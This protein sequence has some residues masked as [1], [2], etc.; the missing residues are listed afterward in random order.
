MQKSHTTQSSVHCDE[1]GCGWSRRVRFEAIPT[2]HR[3][4]CPKC[5]KGEV[6]SDGDLVMY[7]T[8]RTMRA[9]YLDM[10]AQVVSEGATSDAAEGPQLALEVHFKTRRAGR[11]A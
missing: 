9:W 11:P 5:G 2:W 4:P 6:V 10:V 1:P 3:K 8:A 7:E